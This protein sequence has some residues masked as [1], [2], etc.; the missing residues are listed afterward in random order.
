M[1][2]VLQAKA[3]MKIDVHHMKFVIQ[4]FDQSFKQLMV[5]SMPYHLIERK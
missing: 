4:N 1:M 5:G 3:F 2:Q